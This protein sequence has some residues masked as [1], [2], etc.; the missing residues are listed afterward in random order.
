MRGERVDGGSF[1]RIDLASGVTIVRPVTQ[2][3][4]PG[5]RDIA[6]GRFY[7]ICRQDG[8]VGEYDARSL[9]LVRQRTRSTT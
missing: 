6:D 3:E 8:S 2:I 4:G 5:A 1:V 9:R 7:A